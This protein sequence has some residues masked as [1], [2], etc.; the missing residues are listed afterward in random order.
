[1]RFAV[2]FDARFANV[3]GVCEYSWGSRGSGGVRGGVRVGVRVEV[4]MVCG[5]RRD[6]LRGEVREV[7]SGSRGSR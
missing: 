1:M 3:V 2:R 6:E 7:R 5:E 4:R